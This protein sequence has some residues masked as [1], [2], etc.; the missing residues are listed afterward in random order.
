MTWFT[1]AEIFEH[2]YYIGAHQI[3]TNSSP[4]IE[5][6]FFKLNTYDWN[7]L[8]F[9]IETHLEFLNETLFRFLFI[10]AFIGNSKAQF[11]QK[12][13][14]RRKQ[15]EYGMFVSKINKFIYSFTYKYIKHTKNVL[16]QLYTG[17]INYSFLDESLFA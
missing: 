3:G 15:K 6:S 4:L 10:V 13:S 11:L 8:E 1:S 7:L 2:E 5:I 17:Q 14:L 16:C 12:S 9:E